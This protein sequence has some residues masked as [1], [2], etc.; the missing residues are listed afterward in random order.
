VPIKRQYKIVGDDDSNSSGTADSKVNIVFHY[1]PSVDELNGIAEGNL[2]MFLTQTNGA[3]YTA[4]DGTLY[5][6]QRIVVRTDLPSLTNYTLTLGD[7]TN[8]LPVSLVAFGATRNGTNALLSWTT[9]SEERN[10]GFNVQV[11]TDGA[12]FRTLSFVA[13]QSPNSSTTL[14][15][16]YTDVEAGKTGTR[17]YRLEQVDEGGAKNYSPVRIL[18]FSS[19][20]TGTGALVAYPNPFNEGVSLSLDGGAIADGTAI[21]KL[22]D[23]TGR[24]VRESKLPLVG[25]SLTLSDLSALRSGLYLAKVTLPD[26]SMQTVRISKL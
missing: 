18:N 23:M 4:V 13:S 15:Y 19:S 9:A 22:V 17:Y 20:A 25:S 12:N 21:V 8:P 2:T 7:K 24:T 6:S 11:S 3:P 1:L 5:A 10:T 16:K 26:G 14:N